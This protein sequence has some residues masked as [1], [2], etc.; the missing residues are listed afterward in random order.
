MG[1]D[2]C[3]TKDIEPLPVAQ[4]W[5]QH[6]RFIPTLYLP[7]QAY[8]QWMQFFPH[9]TRHNFGYHFRTAIDFC[10]DVNFLFL[11]IGNCSLE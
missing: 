9:L 4:H 3:A 5:S 2:G 6:F 1:S 11:F 10:F 8:S 7:V